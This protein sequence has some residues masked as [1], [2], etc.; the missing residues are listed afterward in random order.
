MCL[1][2]AKLLQKVSDND[3]HDKFTVWMTSGMLRIASNGS[4]I[5]IIPKNFSFKRRCSTHSADRANVFADNS[6]SFHYLII[7]NYN[8]IH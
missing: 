4:K 7:N 2:G 5:K 3:S 1:Q 6:Y 8:A